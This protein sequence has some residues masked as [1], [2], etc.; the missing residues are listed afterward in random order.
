MRE[1]GD[2]IVLIG[3]MGSGKS[4]VGEQLAERL[5]L[6]CIETDELVQKKLDLEIPEIFE[7]FGED[8]FRDAENAVLETLSPNPAVVLITGGGTVLRRENVKLLHRLG[9]I[10][11]L[12]ANEAVLFERVSRQNNRPL[13]RT[14]NPRATLRGLY[15]AREPLYREAADLELDTSYHS[16]NEIAELIVQKHGG[17]RLEIR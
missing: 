8:R 3:F 2:G 15:A 5:S 10:V 16:I 11:H 14:T 6:P 13:L 1:C 9:M 12:F 7:Q 4:A 17:L